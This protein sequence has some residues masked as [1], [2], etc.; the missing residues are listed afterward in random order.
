VVLAAGFFAFAP[1]ANAQVGISIRVGNPGPAFRPLPAPVYRPAPIVVAPPVIAPVPYPVYRPAP[2][3]AAPPVVV[4]DHHYYVVLYR[5][6][7]HDPWQTFRVYHNHDR[8]ND[9]A[10][11]LRYRG[12]QAFVDHR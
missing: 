4:H 11:Q 5:D 3:V 2:V 6:C 7:A 9:V 10:D 8:A 12:Y 1:S